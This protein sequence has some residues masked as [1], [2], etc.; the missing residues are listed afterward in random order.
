[1]NAFPRIEAIQILLAKSQEHGIGTV[2]IIERSSFYGTEREVFAYQNHL[3]RNTY[4]ICARGSEN[5]SFRLYE[6]LNF[7]R[8]PVIVDTEMELPKEINWD[9]LSIVVPY[10]SV[11]SI[12]DAILR[13]YES[14]SADDFLQRQREAFSTMTELR[15]MRWVRRLAKEIA[16]PAGEK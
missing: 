7:G 13:D 15:T 9:R 3:K 12:Y 11:E 14:R 8:V 2:D 10:N 1:M 4:I 6:T 5:Y 16:I